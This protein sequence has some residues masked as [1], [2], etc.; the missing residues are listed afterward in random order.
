MSAQFDD[1]SDSPQ[2]LT[3][4]LLYGLLFGNVLAILV[5]VAFVA[6]AGLSGPSLEENAVLTVGLLNLFGVALPVLA[7]A[8]RRG[9]NPWWIVTMGLNVMQIVRLLPALVV[10]GAWGA[11]SVAGALWTFLFVPFL[12]ALAALGVVLSVREAGRSRRRRRRRLAT[13]A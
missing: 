9:A 4:Q 6:G 13:A 12:G 1:G 5:V 2:S 3:T 10:I 11:D 7:A 8:M